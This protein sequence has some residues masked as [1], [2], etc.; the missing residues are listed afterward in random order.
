MDVLNDPTL[1]S[2]NGDITTK[3]ILKKFGGRVNGGHAAY[4]DANDIVGGRGDNPARPHA[5]RVETD[6]QVRE[7]G[8][9]EERSVRPVQD[10][11][12]QPY[13]NPSQPSTPPQTYRN[14]DDPQRS[15]Y[16]E[17][18][19][20]SSEQRRQWRNSQGRPNNSVGVGG[21]PS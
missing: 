7:A 19:E 14:L 3:E 8:W 16:G 15:P 5:R 11:P 10:V 21:T 18:A 2:N 20:P 4:G 6:P 12:T 9:E 1:F 17:G 13:A